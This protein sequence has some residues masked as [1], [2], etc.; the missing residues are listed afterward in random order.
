MSILTRAADTAYAFRFLRLLTTPWEKTNAFRLGII[1]KNGRVL[2]KQRDLRTSEERSAYNLFHRLIFNLKRILNKIPGGKTTLGSYIAALWLLKEN[3]GM[4]EEKIA[5]IIERS[6]YI[7]GTPLS[8]SVNATLSGEYF[9]NKAIAFPLTGE[10]LALEGSSLVIEEFVGSMFSV[11]VYR[12]IHETGQH[13]F[14]T[15][16]DVHE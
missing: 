6:G 1:D 16:L 5:Y 7:V 14:I 15:P 11:P 3:T 4:T 12:A 9:L 10:E 8:E 13:I 2:R